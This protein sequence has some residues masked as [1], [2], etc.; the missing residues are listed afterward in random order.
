VNADHIPYSAALKQI[1]GKKAELENCKFHL[2]GTEQ[3]ITVLSQKIVNLKR[4]KAALSRT[5]IIASAH[6]FSVVKR[7]LAY[8]EHHLTQATNERCRLQ[9]LQ[10]ALE[11]ELERLQASLPSNE[12]KLLRMRRE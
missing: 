10:T 6:A 2:A 8:V 11:S 9:I 3:Q 7:E 4:N 1:E 5:S 12:F